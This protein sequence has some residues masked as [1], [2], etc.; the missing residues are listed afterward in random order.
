M[1]HINHRRTRI[2][3]EIRAEMGRQR[4]SLSSLAT[5]AGIS[6]STL[7]RRLNGVRPFLLEEVDAICHSLSVPMADILTRAE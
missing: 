4:V 1:N 6:P 3:A 5:D 2:A 7:S